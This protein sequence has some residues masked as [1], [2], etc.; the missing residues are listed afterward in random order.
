MFEH[1]YQS[2]ITV[3]WP[4]PEYSRLPPRRTGAHPHDVGR[5][6]GGQAFRELQ[7]LECI[8][9]DLRLNHVRGNAAQVVDLLFDFA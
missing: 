6:I 1:G 3:L 9:I 5:E 8:V 2:R 4:W 7:A